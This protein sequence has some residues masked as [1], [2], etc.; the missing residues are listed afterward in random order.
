LEVGFDFCCGGTRAVYGRDRC[1]LPPRSVRR[2]AVTAVMAR[3]GRAARIRRLLGQGGMGRVYEGQRRDLK[4]RVAI[5][6]V[7]ASIAMAIVD[8]RAAPREGK[9]D[10]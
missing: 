6:T 8:A 5:K 1:V 10:G 2:A 3:P 4:K 7:I 9:R